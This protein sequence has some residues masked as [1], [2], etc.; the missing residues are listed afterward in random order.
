MFVT[1]LFVASIFG[2]LAYEVRLSRREDSH[3]DSIYNLDKEL[4]DRSP[5]VTATCRPDLPDWLMRLIGPASVPKFMWR[6]REL[7][8]S[9]NF[10]GDFSTLSVALPHL[11]ELS[12]AS[13]LS[14]DVSS[15]GP[16]IP[17]DEIARLPQVRN[18]ELYSLDY[19]EE[20]PW[21]IRAGDLIKLRH[22]D[23]LI[24]PSRSSLSTEC[25]VIL[26]KEMPSCRVEF[27][28]EE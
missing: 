6:Y 28:D 23:L 4:G 13:S 26:E 12:R 27:A 16:E 14:V 1:T 9:P 5:Y 8:M 18:L 2:W 24:L 21:Q 10:D 7:H 11:L 19:E 3:V 15:C 22:L 17:F 25:A 20:E